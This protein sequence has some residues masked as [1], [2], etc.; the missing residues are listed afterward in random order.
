M[1]R[2]IQNLGAHAKTDNFFFTLVLLALIGFT[3]FSGGTAVILASQLLSEAAINVAEAPDL[4]GPPIL[5]S[6]R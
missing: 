5:P 6:W 4:T 3:L 2:N 1:K